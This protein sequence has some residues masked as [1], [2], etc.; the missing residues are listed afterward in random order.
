[1]PLAITH[2]RHHRFVHCILLTLRQ[3]EGIKHDVVNHP[4]L[5]RWMQDIP[6]RGLE[7]SLVNPAFLGGI[8][9]APIFVLVSFNT[10]DAT[11]IVG[12]PNDIQ[13]QL[14]HSAVHRHT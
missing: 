7:G 4:A 1:M 5:A 13:H 8:D 12:D 10:H 6:V 3:T 9:E 14:E 11:T 2:Q